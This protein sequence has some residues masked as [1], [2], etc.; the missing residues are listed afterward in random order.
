MRCVG[1]LPPAAFAAASR[2]PRHSNGNSY[3]ALADRRSESTTAG[4]ALGCASG[5]QPKLGLTVRCGD[6]ALERK[7]MPFW[8]FFYV[9][10]KYQN[11]AIFVN[12]ERFRLCLS[13]PSTRCARF[14][15]TAVCGVRSPRY[16]SNLETAQLLGLVSKV[17]TVGAF[18]GWR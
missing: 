4:S 1:A 8:A 2:H 18:S 9:Q 17:S 12:I 14:G 3:M 13:N 16:P 7:N 10:P 15:G 5:R 6:L 11:G